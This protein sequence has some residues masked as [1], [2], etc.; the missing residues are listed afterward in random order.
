MASNATSQA[1]AGKDQATQRAKVANTA[2]VK[3]RC[4][5]GGEWKAPDQYSNNKLRKF[6][7]SRTATIHNSGIP[8]REHSNNQAHELECEGPCGRT[9]N[10]QRFFSKKWQIRQETNEVLPLPGAE[11]SAGDVAALGP[12][13]FQAG[14]L[15]DEMVFDQ[16]TQTRVD[17]DDE[18]FTETDGESSIL[19]SSEM[20][21]TT[22]EDDSEAGESTGGPDWF[23]PP[24]DPL[25][26]SLP[27]SQAASVAAPSTVGAGRAKGYGRAIS[28]NAWGP[29]GQKT[30]MIKNPSIA[31]ETTT[32]FTRSVVET[33]VTETKSGWP[34]IPGRKHPPQLPDYLRFRSSTIDENTAMIGE[35]AADQW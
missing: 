27:G 16:D 32:T 30:R 5:I 31:S 20:P 25:A 17:E 19:A 8:C 26:A 2:A 4:S 14:S 34:K 35:H 22:L 18:V 10:I 29:D 15:S 13:A 9:R 24:D 21:P 23:M 7:A 3:I 1:S 6:Y 33:P 28:F 12:P 11:L